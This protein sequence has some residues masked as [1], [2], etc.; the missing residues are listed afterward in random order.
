MSHKGQ[1][2]SEE[3]Y[4]VN[5]P[6]WLCQAGK[7]DHARRTLTR[8]RSGCTEADV[9]V[10]LERIQAAIELDQA[11]AAETGWS[12]LFKGADLRRTLTVVGVMCFAQANGTS[13]TSHP[14]RPDF[15][16]LRSLAITRSSISMPLVSRTFT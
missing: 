8:L 2:F 9:E 1:G 3:A 7:I 15:Q 13:G 5:S 14:G 10:E 6:R 11:I 16:V 4:L 12:Q